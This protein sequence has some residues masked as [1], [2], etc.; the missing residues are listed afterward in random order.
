MFGVTL[1]EKCVLERVHIRHGVGV[2]N[3]VTANGLEPFNRDFVQREGVRTDRVSLEC[4][5]PFHQCGEGKYDFRFLEI[6]LVLTEVLECVRFRGAF[7]T[8]P[9]AATI[10]IPSDVKVSVFAFG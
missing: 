3:L 6:Y 9:P 7:C 2:E 4:D 5:E 10:V 8:L 1:S